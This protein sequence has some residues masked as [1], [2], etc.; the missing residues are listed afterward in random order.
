MNRTDVER[1]AG[2]YREWL[3][4]R[5]LPPLGQGVRVNFNHGTTSQSVTV[6]VEEM[7]RALEQARV[8]VQRLRGRR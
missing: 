7:L 3:A 1:V 4:T 2:A 5:D 6:R 8:N